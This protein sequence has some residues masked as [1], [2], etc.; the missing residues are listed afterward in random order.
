M[1]V[2][3]EIENFPSLSSVLQELEKLEKKG[4]SYSPKPVR[5]TI[6]NEIRKVRSLTILAPELPQQ[7]Q[8]GRRGSDPTSDRSGSSVPQPRLR[9][10]SALLP[11]ID[12]AILEGD[13]RLT[14]N[15]KKLSNEE[16]ALLYEDVLKPLDF[17]SILFQRMK[18]ADL[19]KAEEAQRFRKRD[20][21]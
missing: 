1:S 5:R 21:S 6:D 9:F 19:K 15:S 16:L 14:E 7:K 20:L 12:P 18:L 17:N 3:V 13:T 4:P 11:S 10:Q 2:I 8:A